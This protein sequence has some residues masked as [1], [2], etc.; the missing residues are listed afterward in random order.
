M[1]CSGAGPL[2]AARDFVENVSENN[3]IINHSE[4]RQQY[5]N[6]LKNG[7]QY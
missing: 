3:K 6:N 4:E 7:L 2:G 1:I 5:R